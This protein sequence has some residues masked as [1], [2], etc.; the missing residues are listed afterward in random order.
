MN[1][2]RLA[3]YCDRT[4]EIA[5][6]AIIFYIPIATALIESFM[7]FAILGWLVKKI[8]VQPRQNPFAKTPLNKAI[9]F[10]TLACFLS[11][12]LSSN[13]GISLKNFIGKNLEYLLFFFIVIEAVNKRVL[14]NILF[15]LI[16]STGLLAV[17][18]LSQYF[19]HIDFLR[20]RNQ[21]IEGRINGPFTTPNDYANF[22]VTLLPIVASVAFIKFKKIA[23]RVAVITVALAVFV[24]LIFS[25]TRSA[26]VALLMALP[27]LLALKNRKLFLLALVLIIIVISLTSILPA[28]ARFQITHFLDLSKGWTSV[29]RQILWKMGIKMFLDRPITGQG[30][31]TFMYNFNKF[32]PNDYP[33]NWGISYAHNCFIQIAAETGILG[34]LSF[35]SI[36]AI[37]FVL[38]F[39]SLAKIKEKRYYY[40][41]SGLLIS[42]FIYLTSSFFD[43]NLYSLPLSFLFWLIMSLITKITMMISKESL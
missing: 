32:K 37:L 27:L 10:Y 14:R 11:V 8:F 26:W 15:V 29:H 24:C 28:P 39:K 4:I 40:I 43:T 3:K 36:I 42:L 6:Y 13:Q 19:T 18:G 12:L 2:D 21:A 38:S 25:T 16:L 23:L 41:L 31:A 35:I 17:D 7:G 20:H 22:M 34:L 33:E 30:L 9:L 5:L 1:R